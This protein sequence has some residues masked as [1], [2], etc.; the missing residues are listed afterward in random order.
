M[1]PLAR[2]HTA[3]ALLCLWILPGS[4]RFLH[5][6]SASPPQPSS[7]VLSANPSLAILGQA[8]TLTASVTPSA[9]TGEVTFYDGTTV[10]GVAAVSGGQATLT[11]LLLPFGHRSLKAFYSGDST[12]AKSLST[13]VIEVVTTQPADSLLAM[14]NYPVGSFPQAIA[15]G[16]FNGDGK[17]DLVVVAQR[18]LDILLGNGDGTFQAARAITDAGANGPNSPMAVGDFNATASWTWWYATRATGPAF[19]SAT[20]TERSRRPLTSEPE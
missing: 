5:A 12:Y 20:E 4:P 10:L 6:A 15:M 7:V 3:L 11:T 18:G 19:C 14:T 16:D 9:A 2:S 17:I 1:A 8:V 13:A